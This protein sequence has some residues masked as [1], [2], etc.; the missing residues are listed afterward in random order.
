MVL[1]A[2]ESSASSFLLR[3]KSLKEEKLPGVILLTSVPI[4]IVKG[5]RFVTNRGRVLSIGLWGQRQERFSAPQLDGRELV[6]IYCSWQHRALPASVMQT[7]GVLSRDHGTYDASSSTT[8]AT[9]A[10]DFVW[11][12]EPL[13]NTLIETGRVWGEWSYT[14]PAGQ[15]FSFP[16]SGSVVSWLDCSRSIAE[17]EVVSCH[18][19]YEHRLNVVGVAFQYADGDHERVTIGYTELRPEEEPEVE[20]FRHWCQCK[21]GGLAASYADDGPHCRSERWEPAQECLQALKIWLDK[22]GALSGMQFVDGAGNQS[23]FW[24]FRSDEGTSGEISFGEE[25][26]QAVGVKVFMNGNHRS[27]TYDDLVVVAL[28]AVSKA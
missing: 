12:H 26:S 1:G 28:Q 10:H 6:G 3:S 2:S 4:S 23:P 8:E 18:T 13:P 17:V 24:G 19:Q 21:R 5:L 15:R 27:V 7:F 9:D 25:D 16:A 22:H 11:D 20:R 14:I